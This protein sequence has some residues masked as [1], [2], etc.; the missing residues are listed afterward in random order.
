MVRKGN[1]DEGFANA[2]ISWRDT[3][4]TQRVDHA[5]IEPETSVA[6][7]DEGGIMNVQTS[8][9]YTFRDRRQIAP[10]LNLPFNRVRVVQ[11]VTGGAFGGKDD[12]TTEI[13]AA[14]LAYHTRRPVRLTWS[15]SESMMCSTKRH[16][17]ILKVKTGCDAEGQ[18]QALEGTIY[19]DKGAY[20]SIG[21]FITKK[22]GCIY[23]AR[24]TCPT[25]GLIPMPFT[26]TTQYADP[27]GGLV[28]CRLLLR[29]SRRWS[30]LRRR[31]A[32][33]LGSFE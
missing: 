12:V 23:P 30:S 4:T 22:G 10:V 3:Y 14:L 5:Y 9:Q 11:M 27:T 13:Q 33:I 21:H 7:F 25:Y 16:P 28:F 2:N 26:P 20:C 32:W 15:R 18:L 6:F 29:M 19:S 1:V 31:S 24:I 8:T 17:M